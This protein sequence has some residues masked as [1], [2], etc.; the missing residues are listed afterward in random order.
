VKGEFMISVLKRPM[1]LA[2]IITSSFLL[3]TSFWV[4][5]HSSRPA[6]VEK[7]VDRASQLLQQAAPAPW[8]RTER[9]VAALQQ[10]VRDN[11]KSARNR[12]LLGSTYLQKARETG[13]PSY[14]SKAE[15]LFKKALELDGRDFEAMAGMGSLSLSRHQF[16]DALRWGEK[17]LTVNPW[18][19]EL[20]GVVG[21]ACVELGEYERAVKTFQRM[22]DLKPQLSAYSRVSYVRELYGD[23]KGAIE[24]M[25][26]A[27]SSG[28]P[29]RENTAWCQVQLG[30]LYFNEGN[31][32]MA[33][34]EYQMA[35]KHLPK[36]VHALAGLARLRVAQN[37][38]DE[39]V[40]LYEEVVTAMPL[41]EY[42]IALGDLYQGLGKSDL[43]KRQYELVLAMQQLYRA[44]GVDTE[45]EMALF[46]AD[47]DLNVPAAL[48][49]AKKQ[50]QKQANIKAADVLAWTLYKSG[51]Y[52][53]A[54]SAI[55]NAL[56]LG[57]KE[58]LF[59]YHAGMIHYKA[60]QKA[61]AKEYLSRALALNPQFSVRHAPVAKRVLEELRQS[62]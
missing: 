54:Q 45:M 40:R 11:P 60:G 35:L 15:E 53:E 41:P 8:S 50:I 46:E 39:G 5:L 30:H 38:L 24:A 49:Q 56:R 33:E 1:L 9:N 37:K 32:H 58:P 28:A 3:V 31:Y 21:D 18:S 43:A 20:H 6:K 62:T 61:K 12:T 47:H 17:G 19:P 13:D 2:L 26:M 7:R 48:E 42:V 52:E 4:S 14:L 23:T 34:L 25:S 57:T 59:L 10:Y 27:V 36:Y 55:Q 22:V 29:N 51:Q 16:W 44:N